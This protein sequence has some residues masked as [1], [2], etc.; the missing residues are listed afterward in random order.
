MIALFAGSVALIAWNLAG[1]PIYLRW[2]ARARS[3]SMRHGLDP[4]A[5]VS[6]VVAAHNE[7]E[8]IAERVKNLR[9]NGSTVLV[10]IIVASDGSTDRTAERA[11]EAGARVIELERGG[12]VRALHEAV[13]AASGGVI[14][15]TDA[16]TRFEA[17]AIDRLTAPLANP[18]VGIAAGDL[19]YTNPNDSASAE[20][21]SAYW[22]YETAIKRDAS[23]A[24]FLLMGAGGIYAVR[25]DDWPFDLG[26]DLA[27]DS[28]VPLSLHRAGRVNVF[29]SEAVAYER[30][31]ATM[32]EEW[33]RRLRMVA[34]DI[35]VARS[36]SFGLP[37]GKTCFALISQKTIRWFL[38]PLGVAALLSARAAAR[39]FDRAPL[40]RPLA[41]A[42]RAAL[43]AAAFVLAAGAASAAAGRKI[44][45]VSTV[46]YLAG[47]TAAAF[48]GAMLG[49][50]GRSQAAWD[51]APSTRRSDDQR[52]QDTP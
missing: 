27:D 3:G 24:G 39:R 32:A 34:Q 31:G 28:Y 10:D 15:V 42:C 14:V 33:R 19:R 51:K 41:F 7:E 13:R 26:A 40:L 48:A 23:A 21:E 8:V 35:R 2:A 16:N 18:A 30:A 49:L 11:R 44:P 6:V 36:L 50:F 43:P 29:V 46:F 22:D 20:G 38:L 45:I 1:Y 12:K 9:A 5:R 47:A 25:K 37:N 4:A 52:G 17:G